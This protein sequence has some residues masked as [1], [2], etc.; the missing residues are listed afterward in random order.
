MGKYHIIS[1]IN[2]YLVGGILLV[3]E[4][5]AGEGKDCQLCRELE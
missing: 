1:L 2:E 5:V 3:A 4:L